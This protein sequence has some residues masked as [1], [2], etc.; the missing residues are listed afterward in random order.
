MDLHSLV[1]YLH[2]VLFAYWIGGDLG[3]F[4]CGQRLTRDDL[5][6]EERLR[7]REIGVAL[8][9]APKSALVLMIPIGFTL[10]LPYGSPIEGIALGALWIA[11]LAW[12]GLVWFLHLRGKTALGKSLGKLDMMLRYGVGTALLLFALYCVSQGGPLGD[13]WLIAKVFLYGCIVFNGIWLRKIAAGWAP[14]FDLVRAG[15]ADKE[16]GEQLIKERRVMAVRSVLLIWAGVLVM[17][18]LGIVKPF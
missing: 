16:R 18:F 10:A 13:G 7:T 1:L 3:V 15:G 4:L 11:G 9:M 8:D 5:D 2:A 14:A 12:F 17:A 6:F